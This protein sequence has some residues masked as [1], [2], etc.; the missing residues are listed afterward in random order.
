MV[1][2]GTRALQV[3]AP[4]RAHRAAN[5]SA[6]SDQCKLLTRPQESVGGGGGGSGRE[7]KGMQGDGS[8]AVLA[9]IK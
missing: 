4:C 2:V 5:E 8:S 7:G 9:A 1:H 3:I 6:G